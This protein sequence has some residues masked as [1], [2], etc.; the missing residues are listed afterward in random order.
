[1]FLLKFKNKIKKRIDL[2]GENINILLHFD[3]TNLLQT[4]SLDLYLVIT[5]L[6]VFGV[7]N[8]NIL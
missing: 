7:V 3:N 1:M 2:E 5:L 4:F 6:N 8:S